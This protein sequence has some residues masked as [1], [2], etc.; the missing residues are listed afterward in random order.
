M[1]SANEQPKENSQDKSVV[2]QQ[3]EASSGAHG[4]TI[5]DNRAEATSQRKIQD[6]MNA[7]ADAE[8][9]DGTV[10]QRMPNEALQK[11]QKKKGKSLNKKLLDTDDGMEKLIQLLFSEV[12]NAELIMDFPNTRTYGDVY[13]SMQKEI[14]DNVKK[15]SSYLDENEFGAFVTEWNTGLK[16]SDARYYNVK[17]T[18]KGAK[19]V[20]KIPS[21]GYEKPKVDI[22]NWYHKKKLSD[23]KM[24]PS[25]KLA[26]M[27]PDIMDTSDIPEDVIIALKLFFAHT[28]NFVPENNLG[29]DY[30]SSGHGQYYRSSLTHLRKGNSRTLKEGALDFVDQNEGMEDISGRSDT[31]QV[32]NF[33]LR[34]RLMD[35]GKLG[36]NI[37]NMDIYGDDERETLRF[38]AYKSSAG[39]HTGALGLI[40]NVYKTLR[41]GTNER[42]MQKSK[43][44][45]DPSI[46]SPKPIKPV[47]EQD[48]LKRDSKSNYHD[49]MLENRARVVAEVAAKIRQMYPKSSKKKK[50]EH[51]SVEPI[52]S[53][54][55]ASL[56]LQLRY[57]DGFDSESGKWKG[58]VKYSEKEWR[59]L[60][61]NLFNER[62][63]NS[64]VETRITHRGSFGFL[65]PTASSVGDPVR[66]WPGL[67][68][69]SVIEDLI[70]GTIRALDDYEGF[71]YIKE[72]KKE[73]TGMLIE[74]LSDEPA[75][76]I[77]ALK[78]AVKYA[79]NVMADNVLIQG[80]QKLYEWTITRLTKNLQKANYILDPKTK[81]QSDEN[82]YLK[83]TLVIENLMEYSYLLEA[84]RATPVSTQ[85]VYPEYLRNKLG[86]VS[87]GKVDKN[88]RQ[89]TKTF[90]LDSGMQSIAT[91]HLVAKEWLVKNK[92]VSNKTKL[93]TID[94]YSYFEYGMVD[95]TNLNLEAQN[96][97]DKKGQGSTY[98]GNKAFDKMLGTTFKKE[99]PSIISAD[100]N[101]VFT[102]KEVGDDQVQYA[103][104]L[105]HFAGTTKNNAL[106]V[107][108]LDVT[109]ASLDKVAKVNPG[110]GYENYIVVESL[111]KH[112]Q[113]G[114]DKFTMGRLNVIGTPEFIKFASDLVS[115][116][117]TDA[118]DRI[119]SAHRMRM[120]QVFYG[121]D[122]QNTENYYTN[123][124]NNAK[125]YSDFMTYMGHGSEWQALLPK[126]GQK[127]DKSGTKKSDS[128]SKG[129]KDSEIV[130]AMQK[131][132]N[133]SFAEYIDAVKSS[134][135]SKLDLEKAFQAL[136]KFDQNRLVGKANA[137]FTEQD[138]SQYIA[139]FGLADS[140][141]IG[142]TNLGNTCYLAA[143]LNT[144]AFTPYQALFA[145][146]NND[147]VAKLRSSINSILTKISR[148]QLVRGDE[149]GVLLVK[150]NQASLLESPNYHGPQTS[151]LGQR[152]PAEVLE[153]ILGFFGQGSNGAFELSQSY[154]TTLNR[155]NAKQVNADQNKY[156]QVDD[157]GRFQ[158]VNKSYWIIKLP[159][160]QANDL[161]TAIYNYTKPEQLTDV[162]GVR[163]NRVYQSDAQR[164]VTFGNDTPLAITIQLNRW[165]MMGLRVA[166]DS[167]PVDM[168]LKFELNGYEYKLSNVIY[169]HGNSAGGGHYTSGNRLND[170]S[171]Q[172]RNDRDVFTDQYPA[173]RSKFGYIYTYSREQLVDQNN[174]LQV[175]LNNPQP[176]LGLMRPLSLGSL[177]KTDS[178]LSSLTKP[179]LEGKSMLSL[180]S[181]INPTVIISKGESSVFGLFNSILKG[182]SVTNSKKKEGLYGL[183]SEQFGWT[184]SRRI[185]KRPREKP[186]FGLDQ[187]SYEIR[188]FKK[189]KPPEDPISATF[190]MPDSLE[191]NSLF[192]NEQSS[193]QLSKLRSLGGQTFTIIIRPPDNTT[194]SSNDTEFEENFEL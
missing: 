7:S 117:A 127:S 156:S 118:Y 107:P 131:L 45:K 48:L 84:M 86:A 10:V 108:I 106:T 58:A 69:A 126:R 64:K 32:L 183:I 101:P 130:M 104:V 79:Q 37:M 67:A 14:I 16:Q 42:R 124:L 53:G 27:I 4:M 13:Y 87:P 68:P 174:R 134:E 167:H 100:L 34:K 150:L 185:E 60:F 189:R 109:N 113:L 151:L 119:P 184:E 35:V 168:P 128:L 50:G 6:I 114:A 18:G 191:L 3:P 149:I 158:A 152:D 8:P 144:L 129:L 166:K 121:E 80:P 133:K 105:S 24:T 138:K 164:T 2:Q 40:S 47:V 141:N 74:S 132:L 159:I 26:S 153:Y 140:R 65:Y 157:Q 161:Q 12:E 93:K 66:I 75:L 122:S 83:S 49:F 172:H 56:I 160:S 180:M 192:N 186:I 46:W 135:K 188:P 142:I 165:K 136:P 5:V 9:D 29:R 20:R 137:E 187:E 103:K 36:K 11:L 123:Y 143:A 82:D 146:R 116:I 59:E 111:S 55:H 102:N 23:K 62:A 176:S 63:E 177:G 193:N 96:R 76:H 110:A 70:L 170:D 19:Y 1:L 173:A 162:R 112:Q 33:A 81:K 57:P 179:V 97:T 89:T 72:P 71:E 41:V 61:I 194:D 90:Y 169:H 99:A 25:R 73:S 190:I 92:G 171:W 78:S 98:L 17:G 31:Y 139:E 155:N 115:P 38:G 125:N 88:N 43:K 39:S 28:A 52:Q 178:S 163:N 85:D 148:G 22:P 181:E 175:N 145:Q 44:I 120:D 15:L 91:A 154:Q 182:F 94:L 77:E 21:K 147:P 95:K 54:E 30:R 51:I